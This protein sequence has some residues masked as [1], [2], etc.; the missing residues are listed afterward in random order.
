MWKIGKKNYE[1]ADAVWT[2]ALQEGTAG[3][4]LDIMGYIGIQP[5]SI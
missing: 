1:N 2:L 4:R 5:F 3:A